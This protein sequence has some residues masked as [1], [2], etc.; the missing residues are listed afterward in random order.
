LK[1]ISINL[2]IFLDLT[3]VF[4]QSAE[5]A[6]KVMSFGRNNLRIASNNLNKSSSRSHCIFTLKLMRVEN[7]ENPKTA[8]ISRFNFI[9]NLYNTIYILIFLIFCFQHIIL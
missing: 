2:N 3:H 6:Y 5:E 1:N 4:V 9:Y 7:I 8:V